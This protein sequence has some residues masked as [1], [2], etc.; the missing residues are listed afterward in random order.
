MR[1]YQIRYIENIKTVQALLHR[2]DRPGEDFSGW[3]SE[4]KADEA[5]IGRLKAE[6][7]RLLSE[8]LFPMLDRLLEASEEDIGELLDFSDQLMDWSVNLD[9]G[10]YVLIHDALLSLCRLKKDRDGMIRELYKLGMGMYYL[11]RT[12]QGLPGAATRPF[13]FQNE[14]LFTEAGSYLKFFQEIENEE[15][16]GYIIRSLANIA[17]CAPDKK[18][19]VA[20]TSRILKIVRDPYYQALAPGLPWERFYRASNQ[21]MSANR[22]MMSRGDLSSEE[23]SEVLDA[24]YYVFEPEK[25]RKDPNIRWLWPY[26]EMEYSCGFTDAE[27]TAHRL[28]D[29]I[30]SVPKDQFD[31]SGLYGSLQLPIYFGSLLKDNP[32]LLQKPEYVEFLAKAYQIMLRTVSAIPP[33]NYD[34]FF[35]YEI[36][37]IIS[38]YFETEGVMDYR[39]VTELLMKRLFGQEYVKG[40]RTGELMAL[41]GEEIL[42]DSPDFFEDVPEVRVEKDPETKKEV[43]MRLLRDCGLYHD[44]GLLKMNLLRMMNSRNLFENEHRIMML[45]CESGRDDLSRRESTKALADTAYAHHAYYNGGGYPAGYVRRESPYRMM[46]DIAAVC[47]YI[48]ESGETDTEKLSSDILKESGKR[49]SPMVSVLL[50]NSSF[51]QRLSEF[52]HQDERIYWKEIYDSAENTV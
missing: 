36:A 14:M 27:T 45:H 25:D 18:K 47:V 5:E 38:S 26:Y 48:L 6:N 30:E 19:R 11:N 32:S 20:T 43:S 34:D 29:L 31:V 41:F 28:K 51:L 35:Y 37:L 15:T 33:E 21:Q 49:F 52:L 42:R 7:N 22:S 17:I 46:T 24:C 1:D 8:N 3:L 44:F 10:V 2:T 4:K 40:R 23:L 16:K 50:L 13:L 9:I 39:A 12:I